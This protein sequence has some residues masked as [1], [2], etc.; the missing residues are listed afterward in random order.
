MLFPRA[1][2][3]L[4]NASSLSP[5]R[6]LAIILTTGLGVLTIGLGVLMWTRWG[7]A[8]P[9][10]KCAALSLFA[11]LLLLSFCYGTKIFHDTPGS[12]TG[13]GSVT[14]HIVDAPDDEV[15]SPLVDQDA[16]PPDKI[17]AENKSPPLEAEPTIAKAPPAPPTVV[18]KTAP[19][20]PPLLPAP[21][22][23]KEPSAA[24]PDPAAVPDPATVVEAPVPPSPPAAAQ[25]DP[26]PAPE[27]RPPAEPEKIVPVSV[28]SAAP[29]RI[30]DG[31]EL[32][33]V[34]RSRVAA[35]R[36]KIAQRFGG[37]LS[38]E[39]AVES[40]L[41]WLAQNQDEDGRWDASNHG[42]GREARI[43]GHDRGGAGASADTGITALALLAL[44]GNGETHL[45]GK[46]RVAIQH[47]LEFLLREQAADG[48]LAG[49]AELYARMY[50]HA[51]AT[52]AISEAYAL[53]GDKRLRPGVA[54]AIEYTLRAQHSGGGWR[55]RPGDGDPGDTSLFGWQVMALKSADLAGLPI[56][57]D[58]R[59]RLATF[60]RGVS[61]G[62]QRGL[63]SY[64]AGGAP[65]RTM[66]AEAQVC[67]VFLALENNDAA[68]NEAAEYLLEEPPRAGAANY[69]YWYYGT[70]AMFQRQG[71]DWNQWNEA[72]QRQL[73]SRQRHDGPQA[74]SWDADNL[75][76]NYGG[77]VFSTSL[78]ALSLEVYYRYLP[79]YGGE[80]PDHPQLFTERPEPNTR[81]R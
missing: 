41:D 10:A 70:L 66:T 60:L 33:A 37:S 73:L 51:I 58:H 80:D 34:L 65:S 25:K 11:H 13:T 35:D 77:R 3:L 16:P 21:A 50:C 74:G 55:Y 19:A 12:W 38:T 20:A 56:P 9:L 72:M 47:G 24:A 62:P 69:Y 39:A 5:S 44:L 76:G 68:Q 52:L 67:R 36:I 23:E 64:R 42:A 18:M 26:A 6:A 30:G 61:T 4:A 17:P 78:A 29:R 49:E 14:V 40:A 28:A 53:S 46:H 63:A 57:A 7:Q 27:V 48:A 75:W 45:Q 31:G 15:G 59:A 2:T 79:L 81:P 1:L 71:K 8:R 43:H 22:M 32:P 54:K